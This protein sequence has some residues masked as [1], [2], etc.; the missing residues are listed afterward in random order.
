[1]LDGGQGNDTLRGGAGDDTLIGGA[2]ND[3]AEFTGAR[4]AYTVARSST[5]STDLTVTHNNG[6]GIGAS[7]G[8]GIGAVIGA[9]IG[10]DGT[11]SLTSIERLVFA[12]KMLAFG[13]RADDVAKVATALFGTAIANPTSGRLWAIGLSFYDVGYSYDFLI[14]TALSN[15][16][17]DFDNTALANQLLSTVPGT[18]HTPTELI[19]LMGSLGTALAGRAAAVKLMADDPHDMATIDS[20]G[21]RLNGIACDLTVD[22]AV[23]FGLVLG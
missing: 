4:A 10:T 18:G 14:E 20:E 16:F 9:G 6:G 11:D 2:G 3:T 19:T 8:T 23:V 21:L 1:M 22:G 13:P 17:A 15:Y 12:D 5:T 7:V